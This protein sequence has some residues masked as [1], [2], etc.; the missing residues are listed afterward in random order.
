MYSAGGWMMIFGVL[1]SLGFVALSVW[2]VNKMIDQQLEEKQW[3]TRFISLLLAAFLGLFIV[4][5]LV[6]WK[7]QLL[8][9]SMRN[10]LFELI[11]NVVLI[12]FGYQFNA[13][14]KKQN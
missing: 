12:V 9:D 3:L 11:K 6:S 8:N 14:N 13:N 7:I 1:L 4:D 10:S 5:V 2:Y